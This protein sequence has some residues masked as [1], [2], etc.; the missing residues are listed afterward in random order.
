MLGEAGQLEELAD[1]DRVLGKSGA[2]SGLRE[3]Y[4]PPFSPAG[5]RGCG[6]VTPSGVNCPRSSRRNPRAG[7]LAARSPVAAPAS[8]CTDRIRHRPAGLSPVC[9][10]LRRAPVLRHVSGARLTLPTPRSCTWQMVLEFLPPSGGYPERCA[11]IA[12][13]Y[14][15]TLLRCHHGSATKMDLDAAAPIDDES[16]R[17]RALV[18]RMARENRRQGYPGGSWETGSKLGHWHVS[19]RRF[20]NVRPTAFE[21]VPV[22]L[23]W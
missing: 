20:D 14:A 12:C 5:R 4:S 16:T 1:P 7:S 2:R 13:S 23:R 10:D 18:V 22:R 17:S 3:R 9:C 6:T 21:V 11:A 19:S 15:E 8:P